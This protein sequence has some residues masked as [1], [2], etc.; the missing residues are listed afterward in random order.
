MSKLFRRIFTDIKAF[1]KSNLE[2]QGIYCD[3]DEKN[4]YKVR[5]MIIGPK[6]TPYENGY[7]FFRLCFPSDY[8]LNP[9]KVIFYTQGE[10]I[11]FNP[12]LYTTGKV[13]L[14][15]L[16]TWPGPSWSSS[17]SLISVLLSLQTLLNENPIHNEPGWEDIKSNDYRCI[18][19]N[20]I[21]RYANL[22]IAVIKMIENTP[23]EFEVFKDVMLSKLH[24]SKFFF[25]NYMEHKE[26]LNESNILKTEIYSL[27][28]KTNY[29][30][31]R[32]KINDILKIP[33]NKNN[34]FLK[35]D[36]TIDNT[37]IDSN[38]GENIVL[39]KPKRQV[40]EGNANLFEVGYETI[41]ENNGKKY[42]IYLT[43]KNKK[44]W[45]LKID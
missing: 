13:C 30:E 44:R 8:P 28:I 32:Q 42:I 29:S 5:A 40:P 33:I 34:L 7:Y 45:K 1:K 24:T 22:K 18:N 15:I 27:Y 35:Q 2:E 3:F 37:E 31:C 16:G 41:S 12:N 4:V 38:T 19:Y 26:H 14:S 21:L 6:D 17:C 36:D 10:H 9:P 39:T 25:E 43:N 11:R 20:N 23:S